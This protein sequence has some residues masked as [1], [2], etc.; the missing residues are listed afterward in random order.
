MFQ[1]VTLF[2]AKP[3]GELIGRGERTNTDMKRERR[4]KK[5]KQRVHQNASEKKEKSLAEKLKPGGKKY[6]KGE[7]AAVIKKLTKDR[8]IVKMDET[9][10]KITKSSTAFFA[11][12]QDQVKS[13]IKSK[14][15]N[16]VKKKDKHAHSAVKL[17]L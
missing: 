4:K 6:T 13:Q 17:K 7:A 14:A 12:L 9:S 8:N 16:A 5:L 15:G 1:Y 3:R 11:Q 2:L 10:N